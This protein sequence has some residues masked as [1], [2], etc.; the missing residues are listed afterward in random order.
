MEQEGT[1][2]DDN[3]ELTQGHSLLGKRLASEASPGSLTANTEASPPEGTGGTSL[4]DRP[5]DGD[6]V[7]DEHLK[8]IEGNPNTPQK[9]NNKKKVKLID[10]SVQS[11]DPNQISAASEEADRTL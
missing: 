7:V 6:D 4:L 2:D 10:G 11:K 9:S 1:A 3:M 8:G 5:E